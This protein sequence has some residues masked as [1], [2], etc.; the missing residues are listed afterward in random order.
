MGGVDWCQNWG[1]TQYIEGD[2]CMDRFY[3]MKYYSQH[4]L[5]KQSDKDNYKI[6]TKK[7]GVTD[8]R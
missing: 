5:V 4:F 8:R 6:Q 3:K 7:I 2:H 1:K